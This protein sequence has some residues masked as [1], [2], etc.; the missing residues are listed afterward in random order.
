MVMMK[1]PTA[2]V[3]EKGQTERDQR[4]SM[5]DGATRRGERTSD[6]GSREHLLKVESHGLG[7]DKFC[8]SSSDCH[9][10]ERRNQR[11][12]EDAA[13]KEEGERARQFEPSPSFF[14]ALSCHGS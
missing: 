2:R 11:K 10:Y 14:A 6:G 12:V 3:S 13:K 4:T 8:S 7:S 5:R 1:T 9:L